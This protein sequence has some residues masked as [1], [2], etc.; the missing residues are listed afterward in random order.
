MRPPR[1]PR[2]APRFA[3]HRRGARGRRRRRGAH[4]GGRPSACAAY[5]AASPAAYDP[6]AA[7]HPPRAGDITPAQLRALQAGFKD[8]G[9][10]DRKNRLEI[11][12]QIIGRHINS[13]TQLTRAEASTVIDGLNTRRTQQA[14]QAEDPPAIVDV[15]LP[16]AD[17][18]HGDDD[19]TPFRDEP[20]N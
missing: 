15:P 13:A 2:S 4:R 8:I 1:R 9:I 18:W 5:G 7:G 11:T 20:K 10:N 12:R 19:T 3:V 16:D 6:A 17:T 14:Q